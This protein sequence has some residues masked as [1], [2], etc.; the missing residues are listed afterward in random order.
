LELELQVQLELEWPRRWDA[1]DSSKLTAAGL[2]WAGLPRGARRPMHGAFGA[3]GV[4]LVP[5]RKNRPRSRLH[6][7]L[8]GDGSMQRM[9]CLFVSTRSILF[10]VHVHCRFQPTALPAAFRSPRLFRGHSNQPKPPIGCDGRICTC[11]PP[12]A[13]TTVRTTRQHPRQRRRA[14]VRKK[15]EKQKES[16]ASG[17]APP[18]ASRASDPRAHAPRAAWKRGGVECMA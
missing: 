18:T 4:P 8:A 7:R 15:Q 5:K 12:L 2:G 3:E 14:S 1:F 17:C 16:R 6:G 11:A 9:H 10:F 13:P